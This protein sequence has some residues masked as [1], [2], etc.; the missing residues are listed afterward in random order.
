VCL[1]QPWNFTQGAVVCL[2][3]T[4]SRRAG[5]WENGL[6]VFTFFDLSQQKEIEEAEREKP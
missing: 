3:S 2:S 5:E 4:E 1:R 6:H